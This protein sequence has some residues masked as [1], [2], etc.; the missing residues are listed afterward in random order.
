MP[1]DDPLLHTL[2]VAFG[3]PAFRPGQEDAA[4]AA[5]G[6]RDALVVMPTGA[7]KSLTYQ[8]PA[9]CRDDLTLVVSPLVSLMRDQVEQLNA[10]VAGPSAHTAAGAAQARPPAAMLSG[11]QDPAENLAI[12]DRAVAGDLRLLYVAPERFGSAAFLERIR[13][14]RVGL[15]VVDEAHCVSQWGHDFRPDYFRLADAARWLGVSSILAATATATPQVALDIERRL[16]LRDP[17]NVRTGFDRPNLSFVVRRCAGQVER[18]GRLLAALKDEDALPAIVYAGTRDNA[19]RLAADLSAQLG[20]EAVAYHA[21]LDRNRR[22]EAQRRFMSG[23]VPIVCA[24]NAFGMGVDK[25]DVRTVVHDSAPPSVEAWYQEAGRA[26]RDGAPARALLLADGR[27]KGLHRY[28]IERG[29]VDDPTLDRIAGAIVRGSVEGRFDLGVGEL[30]AGDG[31]SARAVLGHLTQAG[32]VQPAP[33]PPD[34]VRGRL[35][36]PYDDRVRHEIRSLAHEAQQKRWAQYR[37]LWKFVEGET[38]R[39]EAVL[40]HFGD[41][42]TPH[43]D[44]PCCDACV[45]LLLPEPE[46]SAGGRGGGRSRSRGPLRALSGN[47]ARTIDRSVVEVVRDANPPVGRTRTV[48]ILR[49]GRS[50]KV[51]ERGYDGLPGYGRHADL[52]DAD[53]LARIDALLESG[54]L[55]SSGGRYPT[56]VLVDDGQLDLEDVA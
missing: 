17:V 33:G 22:D 23:E 45:P 8:L 1:V 44:V 7:G 21:G 30:G 5:Y 37:A 28:F 32:M 11:Q 13:R 14:A 53:V 51:I 49:G 48:E 35:L 4:R 40:H 2:R 29:E 18:R 31:E 19:E 42:A 26:G 36:G 41:R 54:A 3:H 38:C 39:R 9:L 6:G 16:H 55:G 25:A 12:L 43:P 46:P 20:V 34:R 50:Q 24:T 52:R 47:E 10:R 15:F 56:L 27:D